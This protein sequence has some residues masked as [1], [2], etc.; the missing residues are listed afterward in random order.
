MTTNDYSNREIDIMM[1]DIHEKLDA[2]IVQ[3]TK[4]N[5]RISALEKW[6]YIL[7]GGMIIVGA[8]AVNNVTAVIKA[9]SAI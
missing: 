7:T 2:I 8:I 4:T 3:T 1:K 6:R 5:G 9:F